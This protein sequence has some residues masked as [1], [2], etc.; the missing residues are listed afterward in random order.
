[1]Y[2]EVQYCEARQ[3][4]IIPNEARKKKAQ[5]ISSRRRFLSTGLGGCAALSSLLGELLFPTSPPA[6]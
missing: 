3:V 1:M 4:L 6:K 2:M 5:T